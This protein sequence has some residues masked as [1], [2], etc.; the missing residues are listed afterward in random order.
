MRVKLTRVDMAKLKRFSKEI[1]VWEK[2]ARR[3]LKS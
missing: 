2:G 1:K 3:Y